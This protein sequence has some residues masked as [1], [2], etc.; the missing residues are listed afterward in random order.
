MAAASDEGLLFENS[1]ILSF[2]LDT[3]KLCEVKTF[4]KVMAALSLRGGGDST[5]PSTWIK[6]LLKAHQF[7]PR[8][9]LQIA[10]NIGP[11]VSCMCGDTK[12]VF[13]KSNKHWRQSI[14]PFV[15]LIS[16][17]ICFEIEDNLG[18]PDKK[19]GG[20]SGWRN[21]VLISQRSWILKIVQ[22]LLGWGEILRHC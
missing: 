19:K 3:L 13:F 10:Q 17:L 11:L 7:E 6:V 21:I 9:R 15:E 16:I 8:C 12:R 2:V 14:L 5:S 22:R 18:V 4:D 1:G 20:D